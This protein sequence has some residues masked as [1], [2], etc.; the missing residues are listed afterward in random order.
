LE[1]LFAIIICQNCG[2]TNQDVKFCRKCGAL[3]PVSSKS[4]RLRVSASKTKKEKGQKLK[5]LDLQE[6]PKEA[7]SIDQLS[8]ED[9]V[10]EDFMDKDAESINVPESEESLKDKRE[11]LKE[12]TPQPYRSSIIASNSVSILHPSG[13]TSGTQTLPKSTEAEVESTLMKQ[14][15]LE[16]D[17][18]EVLGFLSK[19]ITV[20]KLDTPKSKTKKEQVT[21]KI[22]PASMN[23]ILNQLLTLDLHI[24]ASAIIKSD[25]TILAS[26]LSNR[27]SDTLFATIGQTLNQI[28]ADIINGLSAGSL[29]SISV[30]GTEGVLDLA[31]IGKESQSIKDM[32][33]V[34]YS[35]PKAKSG[36][37]NF[38]ANIV[39]KQLIE[40]LGIKS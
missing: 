12:I 2:A 22:P 18:T 17:M 26:A 40:Y 31:P 1:A 23:E 15:Q 7:E 16:K 9:E 35:Y 10:L 20:K 32:I 36:I 27:I 3:L 8:V 21:E 33:L 11:I 6:I 29:K 38:A 4:P 13:E 28:G 25:G 34:I 5:D 37:I 19:K 39:K 14:K 24:E 30:R